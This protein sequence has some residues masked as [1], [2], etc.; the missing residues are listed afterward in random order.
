MA[1]DSLKAAALLACYFVAGI[2]A[3]Q[4]SDLSTTLLAALLCFVAYLVSLWTLRVTAG[5]LQEVSL[6]PPF[7]IAFFLYSNTYPF[8]LQSG[9][10]L[11]YPGLETSEEYTAIAHAQAT[12]A[13]AIMCALA[14]AGAWRRAHR[15]LQE[16][17]D[18]A[19]PPTTPTGLVIG[20]NILLSLVSLGYFSTIA[21]EISADAGRV[22]IAQNFNLYQW[23]FL[24]WMHLLFYFAAILQASRSPS[25]AA[26]RNRL[27]VAALLV[28]V[29]C[30]MDS[31]VGGRKIIAAA[32]LGTVYGSLRFGVPRVRTILLA[33]PV[34]VLAMSVRAVFYDKFSGEADGFAS[35]ALQLGGEFVFT[36]LTFPTTVAS[37]CGFYESSVSSY[38][39][40]V[41]QFVP[42]MFWDDKPFSLAQSLSNY[43]Y[44]GQEG[45]SIVPMAEAWCTFGNGAGF[46]FPLIAGLLFG[47]LQGI[48]RRLPI[49]GFIVYAHALELNRGEVSYLVLQ[50]ATLYAMYALGGRLAAA[51]RSPDSRA[52]PDASC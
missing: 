37:E 29:Y 41:L 13:L 44:D 14:T 2:I 16:S 42:R 28:A 39:M 36:F 43:L 40:T 35:I 31:A 9:I 25:N 27:I 18:Q 32:L 30:A 49:V 20:G 4:S 51:F 23:V 5:R 6:W 17:V 10:D 46:A 26:A 50:V 24:G 3:T 11:V 7:L 19:Q 8:V 33:V 38:L 21:G 15:P 22:G 1:N 45:F 34:A 12:V 48:S 47:S 52:S